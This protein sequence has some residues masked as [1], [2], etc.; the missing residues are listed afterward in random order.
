MSIGEDRVPDTAIGFI[1][2]ALMRIDRLRADPPHP[3]KLWAG[4]PNPSQ[5]VIQE[6]VNLKWLGMFGAL[7]DVEASLRA[8]LGGMDSSGQ[9]ILELEERVH[10][11]E[12]EAGLEVAWPMVPLK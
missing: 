12:V 6:H 10:A 3:P 4:N 7:R 1:H 8:A 9:R 5:R 2:E 11:L